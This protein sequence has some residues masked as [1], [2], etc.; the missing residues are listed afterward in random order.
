MEKIMTIKSRRGDYTVH[1]EENLEFLKALKQRG[2]F[3]VVDR[4][5]ANLYPEHFLGINPNSLMLFDASEEQ[6]TIDGAIKLCRELVQKSFKKNSILISVGGG[7][8]QDITGFVASTLYRGI[9]WIYVPTT[10][11]AQADSCI[12]SKTSLNLD[13]YK[14]LLGTFYPPA[15]V[16]ISTEFLQTLPRK[17]VYSGMGEVIKLQLINIK[18]D[19]LA[20]INTKLS[21]HRLLDLIHE[22]L[23]IKKAYIEEDEFDMGVRRLLNYGH[24]FGHALES[25]SNFEIPHGLAVVVGMIFANL[26][27]L[28]RNL[29]SENVFTQSIELLLPAFHKEEVCLKEE[30]FDADEIF[31]AMKKDKKRIGD[32][33]SII[34]PNNEFKLNLVHNLSHDEIKRSVL[35]LSQNILTRQTF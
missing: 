18:P 20:E 12:G 14:N 27:S 28:N 8:T 4:N 9:H 24:C 35:E 11:L 31:K 16:F 19:N 1:F 10:L 30:F 2:G 5:V 17:E 25:T 23:L 7:I 34:I 26:V 21:S 15:E 29:I 22:S 33:A 13:S 6:K 3:W 32:A